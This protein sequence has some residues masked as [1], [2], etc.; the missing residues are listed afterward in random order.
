MDM[1]QSSNDKLKLGQD[2][3][4]LM[5]INRVVSAIDAARLAYH[6]N[7]KID[8]ELSMVRISI[9]QKQINDHKVPMLMFTK[10]F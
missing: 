4:D 10:K 9:V 2:G 7:K 3:I 1:R 8:S 6:H 5:I